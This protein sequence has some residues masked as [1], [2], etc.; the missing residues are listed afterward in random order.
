ME[1]SADDIDFFNEWVD[2][3]LKERL[4]NV[5]EKDVARLQYGDA[6][7]LL[8]EHVKE[9]KVKFKLNKEKILQLPRIITWILSDF[10]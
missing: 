1:N 4:L 7:K 6:I 3:D 5:I 10:S 9:K 8:Q 2:K